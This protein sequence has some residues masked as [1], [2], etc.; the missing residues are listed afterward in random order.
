MSNRAATGFLNKMRADVFDD[1]VKKAQRLKL[2]VNVEGPKIATYIN[3]A[4][5]RG[6]LGMF[7]NA[8]VALNSVFFS[9]RLMA[10]R[11]SLMNPVFYA[12][13]SPMV[14]KEALKDLLGLAGVA[15]TTLG[16]AK[17]GGAEIG[18]DPRS[19]DFG[20]I[21]IGNTRYDIG[22]GFLQYMRL[23]AQ[24]ITGEHVSSTTG[25]KTTVGEGYK[26][27]TRAEILGRF[28]GT[29]ESPVA[30]FAMGLLKGKGFA[31]KKFEVGK[32]AGL[33][34]VSMVVQD[35]YDL[36]E[37]RGLE[38][39]LMA[40]P[41]IFGIGVQTYAPNAEEIVRAK[42]SV[43]T[44]AKKMF[45]QGRA[46]EGKNL[47]DKNEDIIKRG[48]KLEPHQKLLNVLRKQKEKIEENVLIEATQKKYLIKNLD[49]QIKKREDAIVEKY[50]DIKKEEELPSDLIEVGEKL[51][52]DLVEVK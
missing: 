3:T 34:F 9:P 8:A 26:P 16:L 23:G 19:A 5:G 24:L 29:K 46:K 33:R 51:P 21:K 22:G 17:M 36:Y 38:G 27:M 28:I 41:A 45:S 43:M 42:N 44:E 10:S 18:Y 1:L 31:G 7:E 14:R 32:E 40:S 50:K 6:N 35:M 4:T 39:L 49:A 13:L 15:T 12:K 2:N 11:V 25:V 20:K 30:S 47:L 37:E 52:D 48:V